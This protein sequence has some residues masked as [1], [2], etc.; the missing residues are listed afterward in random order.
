MLNLNLYQAGRTEPWYTYAS[1]NGDYVI[2]DNSAVRFRID[3]SG[4]AAFS[5]Q[6]IPLQNFRCKQLAQELMH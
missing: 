5:S 4:N 2:Q 1:S 6:P 3:D